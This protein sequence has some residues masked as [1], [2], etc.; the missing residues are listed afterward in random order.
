MKKIIWLPGIKGKDITDGHTDFYARFAKPGTVVAAYD[1]DPES[2]D[3]AVT[4]E[5]LTILRTAKDAT[6]RDLD[7]VVLKALSQ[8]RE[9]YAN[10]D[11]AAGYVNFYVCNGAVIAPEF[12]DK[13]AD[14]DARRKL[15]QLFP[16]HE[17]IQLNI[18]G[19]AAGSGGIHC[20]TQQEPRG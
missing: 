14:A 4:K 17:I 2:F 12:G 16:N 11:F 13:K 8:I 15:K 1:P 5:N 6:G 18:D 9:K 7:V 19:I 20:T 10:D 3:H